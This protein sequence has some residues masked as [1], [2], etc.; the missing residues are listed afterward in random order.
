MLFKDER[1]GMFIHWGIYSVGGWH[2][3]DQWR[4]RI[5][6]E[7]YI[8]Q[9]K[10]FNPTAFDIDKWMEFIKENGMQYI[11]FTTKH[12]DGFCM[13]D[14]KYTDY[15]I[16]NTPYGKDILKEVADGCARHGIK[17]AL[18]YSCPDWNYKHSVNFGGDHQLVRPNEG[19][20]PN[21]ELYKEYI[22]NQMGELL[23]GKY[24]KI[25]ALFWDIPPYNK[26]KSINEF[27]RSL[28]PDILIND[29]G[30]SKGDYSTPERNVPEGK[31]FTSLT[32]A[33]QSVSSLSWGYRSDDDLFSALLLMESIDKIMS[34]GG[35]YLLNIGPDAKGCFPKDAM[36]KV[37]KIGSW[38]NRISESLMGAEFVENS[39][40][41]YRLTT[42]GDYLYV[43][44]DGM[45]ISDGFD[46]RPITSMPTEAIV[47][48]NGTNVCAQ[49]KQIPNNFFITT[50]DI[51]PYLHINKIPVDD[52]TNEPIIIRLKFDNI[53]EVLD[54]LSG[55]SQRSTEIL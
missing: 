34:R 55:K 24:G 46:M 28:Q 15:N 52:L 3:Q 13:W 27:V 53:S 20:E 30:Y 40:I 48:N 19:D 54:V 25:D 12:H 21:E 9:A 35:N 45:A 4:R 18:Y 49:V 38:Y 11:C 50:E 10:V 39:V 29:R 7:E 37:E 6:K 31:A 42:K 8:K 43:H 2:E 17:L 44:F 47:L 33:C 41:P 23:G 26:D 22:K 14:T 16:M 51:V 1:F 32:E 36:K 5:P